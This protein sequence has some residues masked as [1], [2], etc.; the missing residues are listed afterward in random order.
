MRV[1]INRAGVFGPKIF[2][3]RTLT[4]NSHFPVYMHTQQ[5][6]ECI[7]LQLSYFEMINILWLPCS[8]PRLNSKI[9]NLSNNNFGHLTSARLNFSL[10]FVLNIVNDRYII[11]FG[12]YACMKNQLSATD[13]IEK[14]CL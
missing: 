12:K 8:T 4:C 6:L 9:L 14:K 10:F 13:I 7:R 1:E 5:L 11:I 2:P 3:F